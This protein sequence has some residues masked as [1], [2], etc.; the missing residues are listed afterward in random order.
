[1]LVCQKFKH[2]ESM[3]SVAPTHQEEH[4]SVY[5]QPPPAR[6]TVNLLC[7]KN[8]DMDSF[9]SWCHSLFLLTCFLHLAV[10][11]TQCCTSLPFVPPDQLV[12]LMTTLGDWHYLFNHFP[13]GWAFRVIFSLSQLILM[14]TSKFLYRNIYRRNGLRISLTLTQP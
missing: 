4:W 1:M 10:N 2:N 3:Q 12:P 13:V 11:L 8:P 5:L 14:K 7:M 6:A 9:Y